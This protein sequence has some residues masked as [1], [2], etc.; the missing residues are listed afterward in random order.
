MALHFGPLPPAFLP[1]GSGRFFDLQLK[2]AEG[3]PCL[4]SIPDDYNL[5]AFD[6]DLLAR[7]Q[8]TLVRLPVGLSLTDAMLHMV[9]LVPDGESVRILFGDTMVDLSD[10]D[11][12]P[13][14]FVVVKDTVADYPW[15]FAC[16]TDTDVITFASDEPSSTERRQIV[17]GYFQFSDPQL[18]CSVLQSESLACCLTAYAAQ[19][20]L[21][22]VEAHVWYD[23]GHLTL[24]YQSRHKLLVA[25]SFNALTSDG[26]VLR[27]TSAQTAKIRAEAQWYERLPKPLLLNVPR[28]LGSYEENFQ[29]GYELEYMHCPTLSDLRVFGN[30]TTNAWTQILRKCFDIMETCHDIRPD[31]QAP[32]A[33]QPF[34]EMFYNGII[35]EKTRSR[36]AAFCKARNLSPE[37]RI[38]L[39]GQELPPL[40]DIIDDILD[41]IPP[42]T[43][44][45]ITFWH[46]DLFFGNMFYDFGARRAI[47]IDP[48]GLLQEGYFSLYGDWRYDLG[49]LAHSILGGYDATIAGRTLLEKQDD[50]DW[51]FQL[52]MPQTQTEIAALFLLQAETQF[53]I[54]AVE[55]Y[56][57]AAMMF[58]SMLPLHSE[59]EDRQDRLLATGLHLFT[60]KKLMIT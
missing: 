16:Q 21:G 26:Y 25:R 20:T 57:L 32:E 30:L 31:P 55:L 17:C 5:S 6:S 50:L 41:A 23:F 3:G 53:G 35:V 49:K 47:V 7:K 34:S 37:T 44:E 29:A 60:L 51:S 2:Y 24:F 58:F 12:L 42:T 11:T 39:N 28:Y 10:I 18:L 15:T 54:D 56:A 19:K 40:Q 22:L 8:V 48:R 52:D 14:D 33:S 59:D 13:Q 9:E 46:G 4:M 27:K 43:P 1:L 38:R 45:H 36:F